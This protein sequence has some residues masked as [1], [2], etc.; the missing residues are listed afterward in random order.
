[1][2]FLWRAIKTMRKRKSVHSLLIPCGSDYI[3][4]SA[5]WSALRALTSTRAQDAD[6]RGRQRAHLLPCPPGLAHQRG[7]PP[8]A[9]SALLLR[10]SFPFP[11][12]NAQVFS[13]L[14]TRN[15]T[16]SHWTC[17]S[18]EVLFHLS[19][20]FDCWTSAKRGPHF[21]N[22]SHSSLPSFTPRTLQKLLPSKR[23]EPP[24]HQGIWFFSQSSF[25]LTV[26]NM[27]YCWKFDHL[28]ESG[29]LF[30]LFLTFVSWFAHRKC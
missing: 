21:L 28:L 4:L 29:T 26:W 25:F 13:T 22:V 5:L 3:A 12:P 18:L 6:D 11:H 27:W 30:I 10:G 9:P 19:L 16:I 17:C 14:Q 20:L 2:V 23:S 8:P 1:M 24:N 7:P 15:K